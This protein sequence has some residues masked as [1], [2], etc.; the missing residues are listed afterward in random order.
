MNLPTSDKQSFACLASRF[1]YGEEINEQK[2]KMVEKAEQA[3]LDLGFKQLRV[4][5]HGGN[6]ARIEVLPTELE[7][8]FS[9]RDTISKAL[10]EAGFAYI[11]MDL[12]GY[13][14]GAMN[15]VIKK[16]NN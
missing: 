9:L 6:L 10:H 11:T 13:R 3:L 15:E 4:R 16:S 5:I 14:T 8:L 7:K 1:V 12:Q 2:L